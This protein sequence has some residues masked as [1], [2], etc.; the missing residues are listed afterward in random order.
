MSPKDL[1]KEDVI[2]WLQA[3]PNFFLTQPELLSLLHLPADESAPTGATSLAQFQARRTQSELKKLQDQLKSLVTIAA[4]NERLMHRLHAMTLSLLAIE[5]LADFFQALFQQ[6]NQEFGANAITVHFRDI[7]EAL[8]GMA[9]IQS[10]DAKSLS[11]LDEISQPQ[12]AQCGRF[13]KEKLQSLFKNQSTTVRSAAVV[14]I[15]PYGV[16]AIGSDDQAK[17]QP[18]M[19]TLFLELLAGTLRHRLQSALPS[20]NAGN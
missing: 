9:F 10:Y 6:L 17:Y 19:G 13:T 2:A 7:P 12:K 18:Q 20:R 1:L 15:D 11:W 4:E 5:S 14:S 3:N 16:L 8:G